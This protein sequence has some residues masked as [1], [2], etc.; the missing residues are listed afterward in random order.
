M[1]AD[2]VHYR[3]AIGLFN[4]KKFKLGKTSNTTAEILMALKYIHACLSWFLCKLLAIVSL[5]FCMALFL[6]LNFLPLRFFFPVLDDF[7]TFRITSHMYIKISLKFI[8]I[9]L[10][11][12]TINFIEILS[13]WFF[14]ILS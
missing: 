9:I 1:Y 5:P 14:S 7:S 8:Y 3:A 6:L 11:H 4:I 12:K 13:G 10:S 2:I